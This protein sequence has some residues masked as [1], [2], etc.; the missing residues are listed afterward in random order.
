MEHS[1]PLPD[2]V[3][4]R[5]ST[6]VEQAS[7]EILAFLAKLICFRTAS[8]NPEDRL[9]PTEIQ[10][11]HSFLVEAL[12]DETFTVDTWFARPMSFAQ[13]PVIVGTLSGSGGG[14]SIALN[15]HVDVVPA[16]E[17]S[18]WSHDPWGGEISEAN[19]WGRGACDMKAGVTAMIQAVNVLRDAGFRLRGNVFVHIVSDEEVV[20]FGSRECVERAP[21]PDFVIVTEPTGLDVYPAEGGLEHFRIEIEGREE[22]AGRRYSSIYPRETGKGHGVNA[23]EKGILIVQAL[24][25]LERS[26]G[27]RRSHPLLPAGFTTLLPGIFVGGPGGGDNGRLNSITN[28]GT[29]P[30]YCSIEYNLWYYPHETLKE[31]RQ[32]IEGCVAAISNYDP[33]LKGHPPRFTWCLRN[34]SFP[35]TNTDLEHPAVRS[36][37][38]SL[39]RLGSNP[40]VTGFTAAS[41][42]AWYAAKG[43]PGVIFG[44]GD[45]ARAHSADEFVPVSDVLNATK[46]LALILLSWCGYNA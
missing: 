12:K 8:Q 21:R 14:H 32:E 26:W 44:P 15:G 36:L 46:A 35:P 29:T 33:W 31:Y 45:L 20:G 30:N 11:C 22:H 10:A 7:D 38:A 41:D 5:I 27:L 40:R 4:E 2:S 23:V 18:T 3:V 24:Q 25:Q 42:L 28:P 6:R 43:I 16:G 37:L 17:V 39:E 1:T 9:F 34:I 13:H 19:V